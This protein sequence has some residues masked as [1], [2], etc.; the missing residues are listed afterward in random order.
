MRRRI[1]KKERRRYR[2]QAASD[3]PGKDPRQQIVLPEQ[4]SRSDASDDRSSYVD[5]RHLTSSLIMNLQ[6][7]VPSWLTGN[8]KLGSHLR[9]TASATALPSLI[10][11]G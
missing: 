11:S 6:S 5:D 10:T 2:Q 3:G 7:I 1:C 9:H 8:R 4:R